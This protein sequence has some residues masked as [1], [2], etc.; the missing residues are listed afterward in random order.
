MVKQR[1]AHFY[2]TI[3]IILVSVTMGFIVLAYEHLLELEKSNINFSQIP[4]SE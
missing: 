2:S 1:K 3:I 4:V